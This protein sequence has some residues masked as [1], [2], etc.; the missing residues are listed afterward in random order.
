MQLRL[1]VA[2]HSILTRRVGGLAVSAPLH[3]TVALLCLMTWQRQSA[4]TLRPA[5]MAMTFTVT[6][7]EPGGSPGDQVLAEEPATTEPG[8]GDGASTPGLDFDV[9][10]IR[11]R[12]IALF[13]FL[14]VDVMFLESITEP[15]P[16][17]PGKMLNPLLARR[18]P[19][20]ST[21][22]VMS[23][24]AL[25]ETIDRSWAR[26]RRWA[27]FSEV[28][29]L[30][31]T[32]DADT[33]KTPALM[34]AYL[35][36]NQLQPFCDA[37]TKDP[38]F[39][40][41]LENAADHIDFIDYA[42]VFARAHPSSRATTELLFMLDELAQGSRDALLML[43]ETRPTVD[44]RYTATANPAGFAL[45]LELKQHYGDWLREHRLETVQAIK[46]Q[47]DV[48]RLRLLSTIVASTPGGYRAAD[49]RYLT[50]EI[51]FNQGRLKQAIDQWRAIAPDAHDSYAT[52]YTQVR[53]ALDAPQKPEVE[54]ARALRGEYGRWRMF[55]IERLRRFG[56]RCDTF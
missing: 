25:Q 47:Y 30:V 24:G 27:R 40:A 36:Q 29:A 35:D 44:L 53:A 46:A 54:I 34:R 15:S 50:G 17:T 22:L 49:A 14:T 32:H 6:V 55:S 33:G 11:A 48:V 26:R 28:S 52:A 45:A 31:N 5:A 23:D 3:V 18:T 19:S 1:L 51:L 9:A 16:S 39:W 41:M 12:K 42:R 38:R 4:E 8:S 7:P 56:F 10:K 21:P 37:A 43:L 13:P 2:E 20:V